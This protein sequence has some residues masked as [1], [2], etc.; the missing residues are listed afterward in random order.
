MEINTL[1]KYDMSDNPTNC[2]P[3]FKPEGWDEQD[4]HFE[5]KLFVKAKTKSF[6]HIPINMGSVFPKTFNAIEKVNAMNDDEFI[7]LTNDVSPWTEE[8]FF[9]V[10]KDV[11]GQEMVHLTGD[12]I[13][14]VFAGPYKNAPKWEKEM[15]TFVNSKGKEVK[16]SYFF[17]T[18][19]PKCAKFYGKNYVVAVSEVQ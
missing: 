11:P 1:P 5:N 8:H 14:K 13:T 4:L 2:C 6:F 9:S 3:R 17:Y 7:V 10:S 12:Y 16:K 18:T 19:C 15:K